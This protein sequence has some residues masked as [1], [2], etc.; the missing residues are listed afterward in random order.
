MIKKLIYI[1]ILIV[2]FHSPAI[3]KP[4]Q[5]QVQMDNK[6]YSSCYK[7]SSLTLK[8][9]NQNMLLWEHAAEN[10]KKQI[11]L[12]QAM[13]FYYLT[14]AI[15]CLQIDANI[16]LGRVYDAM[17]LDRQSKDFFSRSINMNPLNSKA[18]FYFGNYYF[19]RKD[20]V[21][22]LNFYKNAYT[23]GMS[24]NFELNFRIGVIY[25]K[26]ADLSSAK[27][28][29]KKA[30]ELSPTDTKLPEK[31]RLLDELNYSDSQYYLFRK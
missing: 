9:A 28:F 18:N 2:I 27:V 11:Y 24:D 22:A 16:G 15:D 20:Y 6:I 21:T 5:A 8:Y 31:I 29:Y 1:Y 7:D 3:A 10:A 30:L 12:E 19:K 25:E 26:L 4:H 13:R 14:N 23:N 17:G